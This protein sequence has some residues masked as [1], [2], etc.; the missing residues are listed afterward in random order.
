MEIQPIALPAVDAD[1]ADG[2]VFHSPSEL[3]DL[4]SEKAWST[5]RD[6]D[7]PVMSP[8]SILDQP[9]PSPTEAQRDQFAYHSN[10]RRPSATAEGVESRPIAADA[11]GVT[12][13]AHP[14]SPVSAARLA[15]A[16]GLL[17]SGQ[18]FERWTSTAAGTSVAVESQPIHLFLGDLRDGFAQTP[19]LFW[20]HPRGP[21]STS[22]TGPERHQDEAHCMPLAR[23]TDLFKGAE[24]PEL[25]GA[26]ARPAS[27]VKDE[28]CLVIRS[29]VHT[30]ALQAPDMQVRDD[31][32]QAISVA[33]ELG[34]HKQKNRRQPAAAVADQTIIHPNP[35]SDGVAASSV[36]LLS[37]EKSTKPD[38]TITTAAMAPGAA[39]A[40]SPAPAATS[41]GALSPSV[42]SPTSVDDSPRAPLP[43]G[44]A[45][46][47]VEALATEKAQ[48]LHDIRLSLIETVTESTQLLETGQFAPGPGPGPTAKAPA[49]KEFDFDLKRESSAF[50]RVHP[51]HRAE[52]FEAKAYAPTV[53]ARIRA[54]YGVT[55]DDFL[56]SVAHP[57]K[58]YNDLIVNSKS[59]QFFYYSHDNKYL[60]KTCT[61]E[62]RKTFTQH[63]LRE[64]FAHLA[65]YPDSLL[66]KIYGAFR[67]KVAR[68]HRQT[69]HFFVMANVFHAPPSKPIHVRFD[70]KGST[71]GRRA[72]E[73]ELLQRVPVLKD[74]DYF[75]GVKLP[76]G[77]TLPPTFLHLG[78]RKQVLMAQLRVDVEF[79]RRQAILD[80]SLLV[81]IHYDR[82]DERKKETAAAAAA[83][84][85]AASGSPSLSVGAKDQ[86]QHASE[87]KQP[88]AH[89]QPQQQPHPASAG[90][91]STPPST[92]SSA[93][94]IGLPR[95]NSLAHFVSEHHP[96]TALLQ[97]QR[98]MTMKSI[99]SATGTPV[100]GGRVVGAQSNYGLKPKQVAVPRETL[101]KATMSLMTPE[102]KQQVKQ[103]DAERAHKAR[104]EEKRRS[105]MQQQ[106]Q[107]QQVQPSSS[108]STAGAGVAP[109]STVPPIHV[110]PLPSPHPSPPQRASNLLNEDGGIISESDDPEHDGK[111]VY[112]IGKSTTSERE[113]MNESGSCSISCS[114]FFGWL[115]FSFLSFPSRFRS[116]GVIDILQKWT[117]LKRLEQ[118]IKAIA[119]GGVSRQERRQQA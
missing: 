22:V 87:E 10:S 96:S 54:M 33:L 23:V 3:V 20:C 72:K 13:H 34:L 19:A 81:G 5:P 28:Q 16:F 88:P 30:L 11:D 100:D 41:P 60:L 44:E 79:L 73:S 61:E 89:P 77:R 114:L 42:T 15:D 56:E 98:T 37:A 106:Q 82:L 18:T 2:P 46:A 80:Y 51:S 53:F 43:T 119:I 68:P 31:W 69:V 112:Y 99:G 102:E 90:P 103:H 66:I 45:L 49:S 91:L 29:P 62:E 59:G 110:S 32:V 57:T 36:T 83:A 55:D 58:G 104:D 115:F 17:R 39:V 24:G 71:Y 97:L 14:S 113:A 6:L 63:M 117:N 7:S 84:A 105:I 50:T 8:V 26:M 48:L 40:T 35:S 118:T 9:S 65:A 108:S 74:L 101:K 95:R 109:S 67:V 93:A 85:A 12:L 111:E 4:D 78:R 86:Q 92:S 107:Q 52:A 25:M 1:D 75:E 94:L 38:L 76:D 21:P 47:M 116:S 64:Y 70:L 27:G